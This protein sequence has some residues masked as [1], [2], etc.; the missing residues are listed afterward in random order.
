MPD[1]KKVR[2]ELKR[3]EKLKALEDGDTST[4]ENQKQALQEPKGIEIWE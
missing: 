3:L 4:A 2:E 1:R